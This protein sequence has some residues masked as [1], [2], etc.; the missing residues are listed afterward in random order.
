MCEDGTAM[1]DVLRSAHCDF[2]FSMP[3]LYCHQR[4]IKRLHFTSS[5]WLGEICELLHYC[6]FTFCWGYSQYRN[7]ATAIPVI[8]SL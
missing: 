8:V 4:E 3:V 5:A 2:V 1:S 7:W 6:L